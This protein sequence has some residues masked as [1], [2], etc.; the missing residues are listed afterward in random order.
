[1]RKAA[2]KRLPHGA[3]SN[4]VLAWLWH[5][6]MQAGEPK[7][8]SRA[9]LVAATGLPDT[10]VDKRLHA[11]SEDGGP[12]L[13]VGRGLY[14]PRHHKG[15]APPNKH[16]REAE[17]PGKMHPKVFWGEDVVLLEEWLTIKEYLQRHGELPALEHDEEGFETFPDEAAADS[18]PKPAVLV[19]PSMPTRGIATVFDGDGSLYRVE[20]L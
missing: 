4:L 10:T 12:V 7:P 2:G 11:L 14:A 3:T 18:R 19:L 20:K 17:S 16:G 6:H 9:A 1:M 5:L 13:N 15:N 8:V